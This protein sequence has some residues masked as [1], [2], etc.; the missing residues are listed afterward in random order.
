LSRRNRNCS[1]AGGATVAVATSRPSL[2]EYSTQGIR[3]LLVSPGP[4]KTPFQPA[5]QSSSELLKRFLDDTP[6]KRFGE[7]EEIRELVA[8]YVLSPFM[9]ADGL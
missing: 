5:P 7:P 3:A 9:T 1:Q 8:V 2:P 6:M 4:V